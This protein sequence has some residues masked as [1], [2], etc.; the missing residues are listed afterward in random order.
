MA[1]ITLSFLPNQVKAAFPIPINYSL[2]HSGISLHRLGACLAHCEFT[3]GG[4]GIHISNIIT[5]VF[6]D[7]G[8]YLSRQLLPPTRRK[9]SILKNSEC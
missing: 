4:F 5:T 9:H 6:E 8:P 7:F 2:D 1:T 3:N